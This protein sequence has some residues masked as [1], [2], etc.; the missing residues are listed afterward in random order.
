[1]PRFRFLRARKFDLTK[2]KEMLISAE[3]WRKDF[4]VDEI[5]KFVFLCRVSGER[6]F[7]A[8]SQRL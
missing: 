2:A 4:K 7:D 5:V 3:K 1:M 6:L 8:T